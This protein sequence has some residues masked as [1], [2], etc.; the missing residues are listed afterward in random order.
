MSDVGDVW[1]A[2]VNL[3]A[4]PLPGQTVRLTGRASPQFREESIDFLVT[5]PA[6]PSSVDAIQ[7]RTAS[8]ATWILL[9]GWEL[10][11]RGQR[12]LLRREVAVRASGVEVVG[13][14]APA[15]ARSV[16]SIGPRSG[17]RG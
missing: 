7:C 1:A 17:R 4:V 15:S 12:V 11:T 5:S 3:G 6:Q 8:S 9:T 13:V 16:R 14:Y 10:N 2:D